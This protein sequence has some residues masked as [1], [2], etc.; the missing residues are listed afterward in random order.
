[1]TVLHSD[2][3]YGVWNHKN[4]CSNP[5]PITISCVT[6]DKLYL[7]SPQFLL[8]NGIDNSTVLICKMGLIIVSC[9]TSY[10]KVKILHRERSARCLMHN[11][12]KKNVSSL[13][14]DQ[15]CWTV[16][17]KLALVWSRKRL[18]AKISPSL[19]N[20]PFQWDK[21]MFPNILD[22]RRYKI[23]TQSKSYSY[24]SP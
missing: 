15:F 22:I 4:W 5:L 3:E 24:C 19:K 7:T 18:F 2:Y 17:K 1:M 20:V 14:W 10:S 6:L 9:S 12:S 16:L 13:S 8:K 21:D 11:N 23:Y